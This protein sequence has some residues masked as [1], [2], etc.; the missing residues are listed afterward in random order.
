MKENSSSLERINPHHLQADEVTGDQTYAM[1]MAR[2]E[3]AGKH[4]VP[5]TVADIA[6]GVGYGSYLLATAYGKNIER[7]TSVDIEQEAIAFARLHYAHEKIHFMAADAMTF[8]ATGT[9]NN[10]VSLET[11]EHLPQPVLF[12]RQLSAQLARG[13][14]FIASV[15]VTPSMDANPYHLHDFTTRSFR[16]IFIDA[17][18]KEV[19][20][21]IQVQRYNP[22]VMVQRKEERTRGLRNNLLAYYRQHPQK[23]WLRL[24]SVLTDGFANKYMVATF[25]KL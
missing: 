25:E 3:Y 16:K 19:H 1:H 21:F 9:L 10:I 17:G 18:F 2:Y 6:C 15:P 22:I 11:I 5:G 24:R 23:L 20:S 14:R 12:I 8:R 4:L 7:I 13:G